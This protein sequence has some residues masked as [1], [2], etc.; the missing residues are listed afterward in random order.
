MQGESR[1]DISPCDPMRGV[2]SLERRCCDSALE[3]WY[4]DVFPGFIEKSRDLIIG[5]AGPENV[6]G[7]ILAGSFASCEGSIIILDGNPVFLSDMDLVLVV[8]SPASHAEIYP[9][10]LVIGKDCEDL[11]PGVRFEGRI[12][13]GVISP[14]E[15]S[16]MP[17]SP[18]VFDI[19]ER[20]ALLYGEEQLLERFPSFGAGE[21]GP[22]EALRL[23]ENRMATFLGGRPA[24][25]RPEGK[26]LYRLLYGVS[27]VYTDIL[28]ATF[29]AEGIYRPGY[30]SRAEF[31]TDS[32]EAS[33]VRGDLGGS[34][35][36]AV[37]RWTRF[38]ID[39]VAES[40]WTAEDSAWRIWFEAA[41]DLL[42]ARDRISL[43]DRSGAGGDRPR[44]KEMYRAWNAAFTDSP[45]TD[46]ARLI[47][48]SLI[49]GRMPADAVRK[50]S[51]RL[52]RHAVERGTDG[53][54]GAAP[55]G[56]PHARMSWE[57]AA[58]RTSAEWSRLVM[59][60]EVQS[61]GR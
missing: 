41:A 27:R 1:E 13:I 36:D 34:L 18:G 3:S 14:G 61:H 48:I 60:R 59:G 4:A 19:R 51:V 33:E 40:V 7:L 53:E 54:V 16:A 26:D 11:L 30:L 47:L 21:I 49:A 52:V 24:E 22:G 5:D 15:L 10:R 45:V 35:T 6:V 2:F 38:K 32:Q 58:S 37:V 39:P 17:M 12:D 46:R 25:E 31:L 44:I 8:S 56:F 9:R 28:T 43:K 20:G 57:E 50:E 42:A 55:G 29:C 23:L